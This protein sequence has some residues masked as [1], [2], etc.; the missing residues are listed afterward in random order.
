MRLGVRTRAAAID[1]A[2][3]LGMIAQAA[4]SFQAET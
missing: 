1:K 2:R 3:H 4:V